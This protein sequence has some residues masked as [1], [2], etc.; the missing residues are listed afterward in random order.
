VYVRVS[1]WLFDISGSYDNSFY[2]AG[3]CLFVAGAMLFP[4]PCIRRCRLPGRS[5][6]RPSLV[7]EIDADTLELGPE[8]EST[9]M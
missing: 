2:M 3:S 4:V 6:Q 7:T 9:W 8:T 1:G 5:V